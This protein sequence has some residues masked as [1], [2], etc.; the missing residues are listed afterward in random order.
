MLSIEHL[1]KSYSAPRRFL[2]RQH[3]PFTALD[4]VSLTIRKGESFGVV[5]ESG[6]GKTTLTRCVLGL[7]TVTAG[8]ITLDGEDITRLSGERLRALRSRMQIVFQDPYAS[9]NPR[10]TVEEILCEP[11]RIHRDKLKL[12]GRQQSARA[13]ELLQLVGLRGSQ[14]SR[15]PHEF[16]GGQRQRIGIARALAVEP[17]ILILDEPTSALDVSVQAQVLN[18]LLNLQS[19]LGLTYLFISHDLGVIRYVC[20]RV[21]LLFRGKL[22]EEGATDQIFDQPKEAYTKS[23]LAAMPGIDP[24]DSPFHGRNAGAVPA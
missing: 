18:L 13:R 24:D 21:A 5:G 4:D 16:S 17:E 22:V 10:M 20:D 15:Y 9:L 6:S 2:S 8:R 12:N 3:A 23:L 7:E 19:R 14:A 11:L 1:T